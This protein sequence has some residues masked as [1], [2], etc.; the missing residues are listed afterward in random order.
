MTGYDA[1]IYPL[2]MH[3]KSVQQERNPG[4]WIECRTAADLA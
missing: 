1:V 3:V 4:W 2:T